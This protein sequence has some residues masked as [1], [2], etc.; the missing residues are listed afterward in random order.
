MTANS[1]MADTSLR[2]YAENQETFEG[3]KA[4]VYRIIRDHGPIHGGNIARRMQKPYHS[5]SG[6]ITE[7]K[8]E[9]EI[10]ATDLT[11]NRFGNRVNQYEVKK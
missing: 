8:D 6:R 2:A 1:S 5:I 4:E 3:D 7:L 9:G 10:V 11:T